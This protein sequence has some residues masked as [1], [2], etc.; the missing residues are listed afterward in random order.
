MSSPTR[1]LVMSTGVVKETMDTD[2][3]ST[4]LSSETAVHLDH[5]TTE[6]QQLNAVSQ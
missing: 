4:V 2:A 5:V 1:Y 6:L 3:V